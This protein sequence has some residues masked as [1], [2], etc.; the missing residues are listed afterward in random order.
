MPKGERF[1]YVHKAKVIDGTRCNDQSLDVCVDGQCQPVG[2]DMMLGSEAREDKCRK[3]GGDGSTC[4]TVADKFTINNL[5][6]GYNDIL[7]VPNGATNIRVQE[8]QPSNNYVACR[9]LSGHYYLNGNW[10]ID[11]PRPMFFAGCW[12]NYQRKP[13][14]FAAP[15]YLTCHGPITEAIYIV[16]LVQDKN[17]SLD[18]EY[19]IPTTVNPQSP[20]VYTWTHMEYGPCSASCG[21]GVQSRI[22][23][24]NNRLNLEEVDASYCDQEAKPAETQSCG[25]EP[26]A[27]HWVESEWSKCTKGCG[28]DGM[29]YRSISCERISPTGVR[30]LEDD[31]VCLQ[32]VG[33]KPA[34]QQEC[35][36]DLTN[37]PKYH[38]GPWTPVIYI[39]LYYS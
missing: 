39:Y 5:S 29:Q 35:N 32:Q 8:T 20:D 7:L 27:P 28:E 13:T 6:G 22:V 1:Y 10:R 17:V 19:S 38:L 36:R 15:D 37:C 18:Y 26:C 31:T 33:N 34:T 14:G 25:E 11:F 9:N 2:C 23:T 24:C 30:S 4:K 12:W 16:M 21:G 3:C